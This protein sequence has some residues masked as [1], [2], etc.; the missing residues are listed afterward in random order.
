[1]AK[2]FCGAVAIT[3]KSRG[4]RQDV[5]FRS[6]GF[7]LFFLTNTEPMFLVNHNESEVFELNFIG[8]Q[9]VRTDDDVDRAV[10]D[11]FDRCV[12]FL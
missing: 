7:E 9:F 3:E 6:K 8:E 5:D 10:F 1:M 12:H 4:Q 2:R 11:A